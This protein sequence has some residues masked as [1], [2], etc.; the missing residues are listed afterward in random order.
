M[1]SSAVLNCLGGRF[2]PLALSCGGGNARYRRHPD[3]LRTG[4]TCGLDGGGVRYAGPAAVERSAP[5]DS[6]ARA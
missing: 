4:Q 2:R 6:A 3:P 5:A 1:E